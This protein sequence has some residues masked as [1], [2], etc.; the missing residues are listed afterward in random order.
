MG[1]GRF[2]DNPSERKI[3]YVL[4]RQGAQS[5]RFMDGGQTYL[6]SGQAFILQVPI[7]EPHRI[8]D[9]IKKRG[10]DNAG[11]MLVQSPFNPDDYADLE[12]ARVDF[13][14]KKLILYS[15]VCPAWSKK[16]LH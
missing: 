4:D 11:S 8:T 1:I 7:E 13:A 15:E 10:L 14:V 16:G 9:V 12:T 5:C 3:I 6:T 2:P